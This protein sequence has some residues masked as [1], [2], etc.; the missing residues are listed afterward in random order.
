MARGMHGGGHVWQRGMHDQWACMVRGHAWQGGM[1]GGGHVW[2][3]GGGCAWPEDHAW[4]GVCVAGETA[5]AVG[6][7]HPT[8]MHSSCLSL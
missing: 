4:Q 2:P 6:G 7:A 1:H 3:G 8:G 5:T